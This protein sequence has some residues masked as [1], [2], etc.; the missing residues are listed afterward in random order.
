[1]KTHWGQVVSS[2]SVHQK[3]YGAR[4]LLANCSTLNSPYGNKLCAAMPY[5]QYDTGVSQ[6]RYFIQI[7][8]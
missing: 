5:P 2:Y 6:V 1:M 3:A 4:V 7:P 8:M